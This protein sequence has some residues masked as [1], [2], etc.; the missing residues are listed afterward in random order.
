MITLTPSQDAV[1]KKLKDSTEALS[2]TRIADDLGMNVRTVRKAIT[3]L[4]SEGRVKPIYPLR[5]SVQ[6]WAVINR[7]RRCPV[8]GRTPK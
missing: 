7:N 8:C 3:L 2:I 4:H 1:F 5:S 6:R